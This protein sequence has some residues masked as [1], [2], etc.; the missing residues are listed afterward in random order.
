[1]HELHINTSYYLDCLG[2]HTLNCTHG[3]VRLESGRNERE[4]TL[5]V[6]IGGIWGT[7]CNTGWDSRDAAVVCRQLGFPTN[8]T[9]NVRC[10]RQQLII[11]HYFVP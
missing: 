2:V 3:N 1:M 5:R 6:C 4:G 9:I 11:V 8:G 7:V 10:M